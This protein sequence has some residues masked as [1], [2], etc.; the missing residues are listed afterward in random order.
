MFPQPATSDDVAFWGTLILALTSTNT[1]WIAVT[2]LALAAFFWFNGWRK[3][4]MMKAFIEY[5]A[6][7]DKNAPK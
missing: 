2:F 1:T 5:M 7:Q 3:R 4:R 6:E